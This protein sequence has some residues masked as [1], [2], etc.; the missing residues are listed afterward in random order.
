MKTNTPVNIAEYDEAIVAL[1]QSKLPS[2]IVNLTINLLRDAKKSAELEI[3][4]AKVR[5]AKK[6][7]SEITSKEFFAM[8]GFDNPNLLMVR[9]IGYGRNVYYKLS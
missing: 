6:N 3:A 2:S 7:K 9:A 1:L 4:K 5:E 8:G